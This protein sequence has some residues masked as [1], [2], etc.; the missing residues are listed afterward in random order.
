MTRHA[1]GSAR[2]WA[3]VKEEEQPMAPPTIVT[4][5]PLTG[6]ERATLE[7]LSQAHSERLD[8]VQRARALL[9]VADGAS[10]TA[11]ADRAGFR[12]PSTVSDLI[13]RFNRDGL[14][15]LVIAAGRGRKPTYEAAA[16]ARVVATAQ[17]QPDRK[18]DGTADWSLKTLERA[19]RREGLPRLGATTVRR[20]L[21][22]AG[23]SY[24][25]TRTW[26]PTGTAQ[27]VR[28]AGVVTVTDPDTEVK[29]G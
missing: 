1:C 2:N 19:L 26:C 12:S 14:A 11:A 4:L 27:R 16:R 8:R 10:R 23:S 29:R 24:Q 5:R 7:R 9:A 21:V 17:R 25:R 20:V 3:V 13:A 22:A 18:V 28:K 6:D 15:A